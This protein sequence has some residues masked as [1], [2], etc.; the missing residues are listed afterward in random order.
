MMATR[1]GNDKPLFKVHVEDFPRWV[2]F[3]MAFLMKYYG[4][5][6][7]T[8]VFIPAIESAEETT[9]RLA[10]HEKGNN[11]AYSYLMETCTEGLK[12]NVVARIYKGI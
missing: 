11:V 4:E 6:E 1:N 7:G 5:Y 2:R 3:F 9:V 8:Q 12:T 10:T